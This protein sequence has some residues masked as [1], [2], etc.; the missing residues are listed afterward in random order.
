MGGGYPPQ[1]YGG[2]YP[3]PQ[4]PPQY[5]P[6]GYPP[7]QQ[8]GGGYPPQYPPQG[9][10]P[11]GYPSSQGGYPPQ[12]GGGYPMQQGGYPQQG[13]YGDADR[14]AGGAA[15]CSGR[16]KALL[17]GISYKNTARPLQGCI[18][19]VN[20]IKK[21][22]IEG[23]KFPS[24]SNSMHILTDDQTDA[25]KRPTR[26]NMIA[27]FKWLVEGAAPGD[28]LFLHYSGH[29]GQAEDVDGDE[30]DGFDETILPEDYATRG[31]IVDDEMHE[32]LVKPL[33]PGVRLTVIF[34]SCH[35]GTAL[36]L[37]YVYGE[38]GLIE[39]PDGVN[40]AIAP[41]KYKSKKE[42]KK[43]KKQKKRSGGGGG[44]KVKEK[45]DKKDKKKDKKSKG[46]GGGGYSHSGGYSDSDKASPA[47]IIM[48]SGCRD[49]QT[50]MDT[51]FAGFGRTGAMSYAFITTMQQDRNKIT[52]LELLRGMRQTLNGRF[53]QVPQLSTGHAMDLNT[54]FMI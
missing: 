17:I 18:N 45:K 22:L 47:D 27:Q 4:Y 46:S 37:P 20:N 29:G 52:Y 24:D 42:A 13:G 26:A 21:H 10:P 51:S 12:Q 1:D 48:F 9:Y 6:Q 32:I 30:D 16:R 14:I 28:S 41:S 8:M 11:Q 33:R 34:D 53:Q 25:A 3:P 35:S 49:D 19:D 43:L 54:R 39:G 38:K 7:P 23:F 50:S 44:K 2:G 15:P 31:Q 36:D 40:H 5:P